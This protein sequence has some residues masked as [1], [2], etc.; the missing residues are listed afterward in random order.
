M[1]RLTSCSLIPGDE[2]M[3]TLRLRSLYSSLENDTYELRLGWGQGQG[4]G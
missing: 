1:H 3:R 2:E 4:Q